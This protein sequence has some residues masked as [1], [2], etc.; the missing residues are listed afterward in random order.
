VTT[1]KTIKQHG[2]NE[3]VWRVIGIS[4]CVT[5]ACLAFLVGAFTLVSTIPDT[6]AP[7]VSTV[8]CDTMNETYINSAYTATSIDPETCPITDPSYVKESVLK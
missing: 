4:V 2:R 7:L 6:T 8:H 1:M 5:L 3:R